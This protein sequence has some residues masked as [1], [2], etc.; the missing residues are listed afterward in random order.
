MGCGWKRRQGHPL[1]RACRRR[2][3]VGLRARARELAH[4]LRR[5][6]D[7]A[8]PGQQRASLFCESLAYTLYILG[9]AE[10]SRVWLESAVEQYPRVGKSRKGPAQMLLHVARQ[11]WLDARTTESLE[12]A[13]RA[14][15]RNHVEA[16][17]RD[18]IYKSRVAVAK[19]LRASEHDEREPRAPKRGR[20]DQGD[21]RPYV[22]VAAFHDVLG[23]VKGNK[24]GG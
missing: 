6:L 20:E 15:A 21:Y 24:G 5:A 9:E 10:E 7:F 3:R 1:Q 8:P 23:I 17:P 22:P 4:F 2:C 12:L 14:L 19:V 18:T 13:L 11:R 16:K